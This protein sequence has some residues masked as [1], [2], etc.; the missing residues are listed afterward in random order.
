MAKRVA[1]IS[2]KRPV[3]ELARLDYTI[4]GKLLHLALKHALPTFRSEGGLTTD[5][6]VDLVLDGR[7]TLLFDD[8][9][10]FISAFTPVPLA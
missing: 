1:K 4:K 7:F 6:I 8:D 9:G 3:L 5:Q 2:A 10:A